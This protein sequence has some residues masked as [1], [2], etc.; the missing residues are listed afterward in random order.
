MNPA[1]IGQN[2]KFPCKIQK[3]LKIRL[4]TDPKSQFQTLGSKL[5]RKRPDIQHNFVLQH[6]FRSISNC[7]LILTLQVNI[8]MHEL[9]H[10]T[11]S[12]TVDKL[13][14]LHLHVKRRMR[15]SRHYIKVKA[16]V[17][18]LLQ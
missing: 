12:I 13:G 6:V 17:N 16:H 9:Q 15:T 8:S 7:E 5:N 14:R 3:Y 1:Q 4:E 2:L 11:K 18:F 10:F